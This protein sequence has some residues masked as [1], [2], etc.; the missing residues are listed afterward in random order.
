MNFHIMSQVFHIITFLL[1]LVFVVVGLFVNFFYCYWWW[2][3]LII[4][5]FVFW[6]QHCLKYSL[7][8]NTSL[9]PKSEWQ[10]ITIY[11]DYPL[12]GKEKHINFY[13]TDHVLMDPSLLSA[14][15]C[16]MVIVLF[17]VITTFS[18][19]TVLDQPIVSLLSILI[20]Y[21]KNV[22]V[23]TNE[24]MMCHSLKDN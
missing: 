18:D 22:I 6:W 8:V 17:G 13:L 7:W 21:S 15:K 16:V 1:V 5:I 23:R 10:I 14:R 24:C 20:I 9:Q 4:F 11:K 2:L 19:W 12:N 3:L